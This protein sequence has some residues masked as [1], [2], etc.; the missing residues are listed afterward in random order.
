[1]ENYSVR[2]KQFIYIAHWPPKNRFKIKLESTSFEGCLYKLGDW[3][4]IDTWVSFMTLKGFL[5]KPKTSSLNI[6]CLIYLYNNTVI[7]IFYIGKL[8]HNSLQRYALQC[9]FIWS[10]LVKS[11]NSKYI[12]INYAKE[13]SISAIIPLQVTGEF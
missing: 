2:L 9:T 1:M 4:R 7:M 3:I 6:L 8:F 10:I 5:K 12:L 11:C 13:Y